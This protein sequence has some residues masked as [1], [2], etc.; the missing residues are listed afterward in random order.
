MKCKKCGTD[1]PGGAKFCCNCGTKLEEMKCCTNPECENY[2]QYIIPLESSFC[3]ICGQKIET[4]NLPYNKRHPEMN[5]ISKNVF[6]SEF[7]IEA[8]LALNYGLIFFFP[9]Y[10][11]D[12]RETESDY[13]YMVRK[14]KIGVA[15]FYHEKNFWGKYKAKCYAVL[16]CKYDSVEKVDDGFIGIKDGKTIY[17]DIKGNI[18]K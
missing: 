15:K 1:N 6:E 14:E 3:P 18:L 7:D 5:L 9:E 17:F 2:N 11:E 13:I 8:P 10:I 4:I 12:P 16:D